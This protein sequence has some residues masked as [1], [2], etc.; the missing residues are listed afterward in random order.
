MIAS[1]ANSLIA[2]RL[3][4]TGVLLHVDVFYGEREK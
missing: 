4:E 3:V 1:S 2:I